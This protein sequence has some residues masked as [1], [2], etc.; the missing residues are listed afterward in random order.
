MI[1]ITELEKYYATEE[2]QTIAL[3]KLSFEI[4]EGEFVAIMGP[5][6]CGKSTLLNILGLLDDPDGGNFIFNDIDVTD[7][8]ERKRANLRKHNI[9]FI[10]QSFNLI[11]ELTVFENV[12][13]PLI[14]TGVKVAERKKRV[15]EVLE[16]MQIMHR[17]NHYPQQLSG[18][19]QQRVAVARA[20]IN[21]PKL[22][23]ADEPTG[24]L[25]S[26][27]GN[28]VMQLLTELND[29]GTTIIMVTHSEQDAKYGHRIIRMLDGQK[30]TEN[31]LV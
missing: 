20:V 9:G 11:D 1:K 5:S 14:Y 13:L 25:D 17:R 30:V 19:Q 27:N 8:N 16:K 22:I 6:G 23:L 3:N 24:N 29:Q 26:S 2:V 4:K 21:D 28:E 18:G 31:I 12:E 15:D 7:F 10:F